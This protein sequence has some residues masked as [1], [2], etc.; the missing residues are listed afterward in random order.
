ML[1]IILQ[2]F[3]CLNQRETRVQ[4]VVFLRH[5]AMRM[6]DGLPQW[7]DVANHKSTVTTFQVKRRRDTKVPRV[8]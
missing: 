2:S 6:G 3:L 1:Q 5:N 4:Y 7:L 8:F